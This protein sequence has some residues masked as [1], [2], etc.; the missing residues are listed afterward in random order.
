MVPC[1]RLL[2]EERSKHGLDIWEYRKCAKKSIRYFR[3]EYSCLLDH[4]NIEDKKFDIFALC[5]KCANEAVTRG[6]KFW[7]PREK[8]AHAYGGSHWMDGKPVY[9]IRGTIGS[10]IEI[11]GVESTFRNDLKD[12]KR[13]AI[14]ASLF[15]IM[16]QDCYK[17]LTPDEWKSI[18]TDLYEEFV[19]ESVLHS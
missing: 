11:Q 9:N 19:V 12:R 8:H 5:E 10:V 2:W 3:V 14:K 15:R 6:N 4:R 7:F 18:F 1:T 17:Q 16:R 13:S